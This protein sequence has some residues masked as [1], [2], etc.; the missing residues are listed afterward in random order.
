MTTNFHCS[1]G[2]ADSFL[3]IFGR[4]EYIWHIIVFAWLVSLN[5]TVL[6][7]V[8]VTCISIPRCKTA[9]WNL[10][11]AGFPQHTADIWSADLKPFQALKVY[12]L[13][14][15]AD[16]FAMKGS[17]HLMANSTFQTSLFSAQNFLWFSPL[18]RVFGPHFGMNK[19]SIRVS[20][21]TP[22]PP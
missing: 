4:C 20:N 11:F 6:F 5:A 1:R 7:N 17:F 15:M 12:F 21:R 18:P 14:L 9:A 19:S 8:T 10:S 2:A 3:Y 13:A 16:S 22:C